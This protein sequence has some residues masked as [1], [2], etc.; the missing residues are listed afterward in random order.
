MA[1]TR[2]ITVAELAETFDNRKLGHL[3][4]D[5]DTAI[6]VDESNTVLLNCIERASAMLQAHAVVGNRY[7]LDDLNTIAT[8]DSEWTLKGPVADLAIVKLYEVRGGDSWPEVIKQKQIRSMD[9][10]NRL[11]AG[12]VVFAT[13]DASKTAGN[14]KIMALSAAQRAQLDLSSDSRFF[15]PRRTTV[16]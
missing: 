8:G 3:S 2:Y 14:P 1:Q 13:D 11:K 5:T 9:L 12:E 10:L 6:I 4:S 7:T 15:G 16:I